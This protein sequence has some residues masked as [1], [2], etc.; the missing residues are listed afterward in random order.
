[1]N[2]LISLLL[3]FVIVC[4]FVP[5][6]TFAVQ[7]ETLTLAQLRE[8]FPH[9]KY[10]NHADNPGASNNNQ[11]G[12]TSTPCPRHQ[13]IGTS[14]QTCNG[15]APN[16][17]QLSWQ[18][19]GYAEKLG[20]DATGYNPRE[21]ANGWYTYK[22]VS[23]LD[24]LK[25]GDIV[26]HGSHSIYITAV[27]GETVT[28]TDCNYTKGCG[29]RWDATIT[30]SALRNSFVYL[31]SA[32]F[33]MTGEPVGC[34]CSEE[35]AGTYRCTT[36]TSTLNIR[37]GHGTGYSV[38]G[39]IPPGGVVTVSAASGIG[40]SDWA[41]VEYN[42]ITGYTSMQYLAK[43]TPLEETIWLSSKPMGE[44]LDTVNA[45]D[46][47]YLCYEITDTDSGLE[48]SQLQDKDYTVTETV[49]DPDGSLAYSYSCN[50][51][52]DGYIGIGCY[53]VGTYSYRI[54]LTGDLIGSFAGSFSVTDSDADDLFDL[55]GA[56]MVLGNDLTLYLYINKSDVADEDCYMQITK[57][58]ADGRSDTVKKV[59]I[60]D[61]TDYGSMYRVGFSGVAAKEMTDD[62]TITVYKNDGTQLSNTKV[63]SVADYALAALNSTDTSSIAS[64]T[65]MADM[66][67]YGAAA[68]KQFGYA[69]DDLASDG[70]TQAH[71]A[72]ATQEFSMEQ[73]SN[74]A[75]KGPGFL[76]S[77]LLLE[78]SICLNFYFDPDIVDS[79]MTAKV[80]YTDH[81][82][83]AVNYQIPGSRFF[84]M[85]STGYV[86]VSVSTMAAADMASL[87][88]VEIYDGS[89]LVASGT[90]SI[91]SYTYVGYESYPL[92]TDLM[93]FCTS[94]HRYFH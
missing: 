92:F 87:V 31:Q 25:P 38:V 14:S 23:A 2:R 28:Y 42:G 63:M 41:H 59:S 12:Y 9:G 35:Y 50:G 91:R 3:V 26:R 47:V 1:M 75:V 49:W 11:D 56:N 71:L 85:A 54:E 32:P 70:M 89:E 43:V 94:A 51:Y 15:F 20:Y 16:G 62:L 84:T 21:N 30:M 77:S 72:C 4:S 18:C 69:T 60:S 76:G 53:A 17:R 68:Q 93:K 7:P 73:F 5:V 46:S 8:K 45:G 80:S 33:S 83:T 81:Y 82:G 36:S 27:N 90:N 74:E 22:S 55:A 19:M 10:W 61:W 29:I 88:T 24:N 67:L 37:A 78:S 34:G 52:E 57:S 39:S 66:L 48:L 40:K 79:S 65:L 13:N 64:H 86:G 58:F 44:T 6:E